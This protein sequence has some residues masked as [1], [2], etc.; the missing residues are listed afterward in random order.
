[1]KDIAVSAAK[2]IHFLAIGQT[3]NSHYDSIPTLTDPTS[4]SQRINSRFIKFIYYKNK[5]MQ[6]HGL[7]SIL[8]DS[9][10]KIPQSTMTYTYKQKIA[11]NLSQF[12]VS[13]IGLKIYKNSIVKQVSRLQTRHNEMMQIFRKILATRHPELLA[14]IFKYL[15]HF[16]DQTTI[17]QHTSLKGRANTQVVLNC[18]NT[19]YNSTQTIMIHIHVANRRTH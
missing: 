16:A 3:S 1:M 6:K 18:L 7:N 15:E 9:T 19:K 4:K 2:H 14:H 11:K 13:Q 17:T 12:Q 5:R 10:K 8:T